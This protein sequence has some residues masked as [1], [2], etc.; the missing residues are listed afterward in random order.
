I[1]GFD[2]SAAGSIMGIYMVGVLIGSLALGVLSDKIGPKMTSV[3][4]MVAGA[5]AAG[6]LLTATS[7][8]VLTFAVGLL[9]VISSSIGT[10]GPALASNLF[11]NK[12]YSQI[13]ST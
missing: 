13:Y 12:D 5:V 7:T 8:S 3:L 4:A 11:G 1:K 9:G 6:L 2:A 10:L